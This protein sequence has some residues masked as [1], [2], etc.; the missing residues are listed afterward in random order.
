MYA[1]CRSVQDAWR[2]FNKMPS[3]KVVTWAAMILGHVDCQQG[4]QALELFDKCTGRL[5]MVTFVGLLT[6]H[7][8]SRPRAF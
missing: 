4:Q 5:D 8:T 7:A 2:M 6:A 1:K 3:R